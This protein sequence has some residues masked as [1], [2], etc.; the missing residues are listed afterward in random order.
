MFD[1]K[2]CLVKHHDQDSLIKVL[3]SKIHG[4]KPANQTSRV[5]CNMEDIITQKS[6]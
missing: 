4:G 1:R 3:K 2:F 6:S 5:V